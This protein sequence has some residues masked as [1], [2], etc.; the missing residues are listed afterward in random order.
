MA[1]TET[2]PPL[3]GPTAKEKKYDRQ[4]RL[5]AAAGQAALEEAHL[6]LINASTVGTETLKNLVLPGIGNYTILDSGIVEEADLGVNFFL[7]DD[8]VGGFR[9]EHTCKYLQELNP[10]VKGN[11]ITEPVES[12]LSRPDNLKPY[13]LILASSPIPPELLLIIQ[14]HAEATHTPLFYIHSL[15]FYS[16]FSVHIPPDFPV[17][18]THPDPA[19]LSDLRLLAPWPELTALMR[20]HTTD[21]DAMDHETHGHVPYVL[22]LL[23]YLEQ[24]KE[25]H[26][27]KPPQN[28][29]EKTDFRETVRKGARTNNPEGG[30]ENFDEA[31][32]AVLKNLNMPELGSAVKE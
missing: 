15:G 22:L 5:W 32:G 1:D 9:A 28:Y 14:Q 17:V 2:P 12:V 29:R 21:L 6:L 10:D 8:S 19:T 24:W 27:G 13:S 23:F 20:K 31:V 3:H 25:S 4:L 30:E 18:D 16:H 7:E 11:F 26:N